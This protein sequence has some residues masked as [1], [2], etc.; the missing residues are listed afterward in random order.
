MAGRAPGFWWQAAG[1]QSTLLSPVAAVYG[2]VAAWRM[3]HAAREKLPAPVICVGNFTVGGSGKTPVAIELCRAAQALGLTP[4]FL[5]RGHGG[6]VRQPTLVEPKRHSASDVGDE[7]LLLAAH[8]PTAVA[9]DRAAAARLLLRQGC[10][11]VIMDDG[12]Q[13]ARLQMDLALLVVDA[14]RGL[15]NG[16]VLPAGPLRAPMGA[17]AAWA[18]AVLMVGDGA[19]AERRVAE[20]AAIGRTVL[21]A[22]IVPSNPEIVAGRKVLAFAGIGDPVKFF[23]TVESAGGTIGAQRAFGDHQHLSDPEIASLV[24]DAEAGGLD[25]VTTAK[26][27]ARLRAGTPAAQALGRRTGVLEIRL[28]FE[29]EDLARLLVEQAAEAFARRST[30]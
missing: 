17:Q 6:S 2:Q 29:P 7:P 30:V 4:G 18:D 28:A 11:L 3:S 12:F 1:W 15:G 27:H 10:D 24:R 21:R 23:A 22:R 16:R 5:S 25:L 13:S 19:D 14:R 20:M 26:D 8:A 9:T